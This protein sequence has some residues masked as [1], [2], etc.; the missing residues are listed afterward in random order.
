MILDLLLGP[1]AG[2]I[3][4][5][6]EINLCVFANRVVPE[7]FARPLHAEFFQI[8]KRR[9]CLDCGQADADVERQAKKILAALRVPAAVSSC[10]DPMA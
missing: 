5:S 2:F 1:D 6:P 4:L 10:D 8:A 3:G 7:T 9:E